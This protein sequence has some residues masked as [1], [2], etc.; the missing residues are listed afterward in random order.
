[1]SSQIK[2]VILIGAG[3]KLGPFI[4]SAFDSDP[5]FNITILSRASSTSTF[6]AH[7]KIHTI[8]DDYPELELLKAFKGQDAI[9]STIATASAEQQKSFIEVAIKVGVKRFVPSE[10]GGDV[11]NENAMA[12]LPQFFKGKLDIVEYLKGKEREGLTWT[13]FVTG[14]FFDLAMKI[15]YMGIN[16]QEQK[17]TLY[18]NGT[19]LWCTTTM[20]A[21]GLAVK[22]AMLISEKTANKYM[23]IDSFTV[24]QKQV[25]AAFEKA[26]GKKWPVTYADAEE[27]KK[28]GLEKMAKGDFSGAAQLIRYINLVDGHGGNY[29]QYKEGANELLSVPKQSLD[30][31]VAGIVKG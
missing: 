1:M 17:A 30:G 7:I 25:L 26:T 4:L 28:D 15:G 6:P 8:S 3:G 23:Y 5:R 19:S 22:N 2:N 9:I 10:F 13:S 16:I 14:P 29:M 11:R 24:S 20:A 21:I 31:V 27:D 18:N 12:L